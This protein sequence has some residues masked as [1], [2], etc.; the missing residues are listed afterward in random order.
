MEIKLI[1][2]EIFEPVLGEFLSD[3]SFEFTLLSCG[4]NN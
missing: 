1:D 3:D 4:C 2:E